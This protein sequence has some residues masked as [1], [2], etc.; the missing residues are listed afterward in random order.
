MLSSRLN[1]KEVYLVSLTL[2]DDEDFG[3][4]HTFTWG[5]GLPRQWT[6]IAR[7]PSRSP[8]QGPCLPEFKAEQVEGVQCLTLE[9]RVFPLSRDLG[10]VRYHRDAV[11]EIYGKGREKQVVTYLGGD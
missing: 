8:P 4:L 2:D 1:D 7:V 6:R 5:R 11:S 10:R 3:V 9:P